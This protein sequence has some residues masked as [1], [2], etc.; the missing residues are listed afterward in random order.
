MP[1]EAMHPEAKSLELV[2]LPAL[3]DNYVFLLHDDA[4]G[5]TALIDV[6]E[7][8]PV[9]EALRLRGWT[10]SQIWLTHHHDDH[11]QGLPEVREA[12]P[13]AVVFGA[14]ADAHRLPPMDELLT[15]GERFD[16]AGHKVDVIDVPGHTL[17]H[18]AYHVPGAQV[19]FTGDSLMALGCGRLFEGTPAQMWD[20]LSKL[21]SLPPGTQI[22]SGHEYTTTNAKFA[23]SIEPDNPALIYRISEITHA[24]SR[25]QPTVPSLLQTELDTNPFLRAALPGYGTHVGLPNSEA[26]DIFAKIRKLKDAF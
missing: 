14:A 22:C 12:F 26:V 24:R 23:A 15:G 9:L 11:I 20:S 10:L 7:A 2:T 21:A 17:G 3:S 5:E 1:L 25:N 16:F 6:P 4:S 19:A 18:I 8:A 13:D